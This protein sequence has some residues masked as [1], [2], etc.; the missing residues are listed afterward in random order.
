M[1]HFQTCL[2]IYGNIRLHL[3]N[4]GRICL[5]FFSGCW[6]IPSLL[7]TLTTLFIDTLFLL[8]FTSVFGPRPHLLQLLGADGEGLLGLLGNSTEPKECVPHV[9]ASLCAL[10]MVRRFWIYLLAPPLEDC[11]IQR[12]PLLVWHLFLAAEGERG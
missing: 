6:R 2:L 8:D 4:S 12:R 10:E 11:L 3:L 5:F 7:R 9:G 1:V